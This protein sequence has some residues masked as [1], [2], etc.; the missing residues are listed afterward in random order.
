MEAVVAKSIFITGGTTGIGFDLAR[1]YLEEGCRVA[2]TGRSLSKLPSGAREKYPN[3]V[4]YELDVQDKEGM[5]NAIN[6]FAK[7]GLDVVV[8]NA[9]RSVGEK[10]DIPDFV[11][12]SDV[13]QTNVQGVLNT[14]GPSLK[15]MIPQRSG[16][17]VGIA[18]VA[19][20]VGLP[21]ASFYCASKAAV[22]KMMETWA[23]DL[24]Q[25]NVA[26]TCICPGF[27]DTPLTQQNKHPMPFIMPAEKG[28]RLIKNA[29]DKRKSLY[30]FPWQ[31][32]CVITILNK[33]PRWLYRL[34]MGSSV[35]NYRR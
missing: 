10:N 31:M 25:F 14:F 2:V 1:L 29:I 34:I 23:I 16:Q 15:I 35:G 21:G 22:E 12:G 33:M 30:I 6:D 3:L 26:S 8:A 5:E 24:K 9:G 27:I 4:A 32:K 11:G 13:I 7:S 19:A 17:I 28:A 18:S 20:F